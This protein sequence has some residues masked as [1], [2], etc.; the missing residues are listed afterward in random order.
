VNHW[1]SF[2]FNAK[3]KLRQQKL[4]IAGDENV[5]NTKKHE[6]TSGVQFF[7]EKTDVQF[8]RAFK[9]LHWTL[10]KDGCLSRKDKL[11]I[12]VASAIAAK[13]EKCVKML[14]KEALRQGVKIEELTEATSVAAL[15]CGGSGF[16]FASLVFD[17][18]K[19][20]TNE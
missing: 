19:D 10:M 20:E 6:E 8:S 17:C 16:N 11:L 3:D 7:L 1:S 2:V 5:E 13:C 18:K 14:S 12:A 15:V 9:K 4:P